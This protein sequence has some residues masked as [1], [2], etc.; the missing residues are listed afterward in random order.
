MLTKL[1]VKNYA[2]IDE[3]DIDFGIGLT[4]ITGE[5][6]AGKSILLGALSL[7]LGNRADTAVLLKKTEKCIVEATFDIN[8]YGLGGFFAKYEIDY[9]DLSII[10]REI[11]PVGKSRAFIND[12]PVNL[13]QIKELG[14]K[15]IDIHS[16]H[17]TLMLNENM[18]QLSVLDSFSN[19]AKLRDDYI[20][21]YRAYKAEQKEFESLKENYD[22]NRADFEYYS[23]QIEQL[24]NSKLVAGELEDLE[25]EQEQLTHAE[26]IKTALIMA[27][28]LLMADNAPSILGMIKESKNYLS[29]IAEYLD[30]GKELVSRTESAYIELDDI[31]STITRIAENTEAD[32]ERLTLIKE[33]IDLLLSLMQKHRVNNI[34]EL[35]AKT[36]EIR[37]IVKQLVTSDD[38]ILELESS[39]TK[40]TKILEKLAA[41]ISNSRRAALPNVEHEVTEQ[42]KNLGMPNARFLVELVDTE[43]FTPSGR[44][45]AEFLFSAN[46]QIRP[47]NLARTAS[48]GELSRVMLSLKSFLSRNSGLPTIIFDEIDSG[49][50]GEVADKVGVILSGMGKYMQVINITHLP[51]VAA[52]GNAHYHVY[53]DDTG[54]ST[55]TRIRLLSDKERTIEIARLLS[56]SGIT[57]AAISNAMELIAN[58]QEIN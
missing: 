15:L 17:Q 42:L 1:F 48:G 2:L 27:S 47:E 23:F 21:V 22:K 38:R 4:I 35:T 13:N 16:Q 51:Q 31:S 58:S 33:R 34:D 39:L 11:N 53:K 37:G 52:R 10:R 29:R 19:T 56:G 12:T 43:D 30:N 57:E 26:E 7:V 49:V 8:G 40:K 14:D 50:S 18:F 32:P 46:K 5:T 3:L 25:K 54:D 6:G 36:E 55:V 9:S 28:D 41:D 20:N 45:R 44:N 24:D